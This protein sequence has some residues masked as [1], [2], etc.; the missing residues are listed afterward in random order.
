MGSVKMKIPPF[1]ERADGKPILNE[2]ERWSSSLITRNYSEQKNVRLASIKFFDS[3]AQIWGEQ[4]VWNGRRNRER[5]IESWAEMKVV[6]KKRFVPSH[7]YR[8]L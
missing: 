1:Y 4:L 3:Y 2:K 7:Y 5:P 8:E 6:M